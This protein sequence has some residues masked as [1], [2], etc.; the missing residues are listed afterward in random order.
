[1]NTYIKRTVPATPETSILI[2]TFMTMQISKYN[3]VFSEG[4]KL[5]DLREIQHKFSQKPDLYHSIT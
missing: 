1:M 3:V 5:P 2:I 4:F